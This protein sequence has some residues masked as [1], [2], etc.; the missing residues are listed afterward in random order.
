MLP[1]SRVS[2]LLISCIDI[3]WWNNEKQR[4]VNKW[5]NA[6]CES[7]R[8]F[9]T[10]LP[11]KWKNKSSWAT[12]DRIKPQSSEMFKSSVKAGSWLGKPETLKHGMGTLG[13]CPWRS[14]LCWIPE[15]S[16][17]AELAY[18]S[19]VGSYHLSCQKLL[20]RS[21]PCKTSAPVRTFSHL[22]PGNQNDN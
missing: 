15:I 12:K 13:G 19:L 11:L 16:G 1:R 10:Q 9:W 7:Q 22:L 20:Q 8:A 4:T 18:P 6:K 17:L 2:L 3:L 14:W 5:L 21:I